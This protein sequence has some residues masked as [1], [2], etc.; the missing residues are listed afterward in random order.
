[1]VVLHL[2]FDRTKEKHKN[3]KLRILHR[4][5][6]V[7]VV[8]YYVFFLFFFSFLCDSENGLGRFHDGAP[9]NFCVGFRL[10][11]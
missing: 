7:V 9:G 5:V 2:S 1:M 11:R 8:A 10:V 3:S 4:V 6:L